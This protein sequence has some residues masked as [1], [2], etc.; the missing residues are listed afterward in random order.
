MLLPSYSIG[1]NADRIEQRLRAEFS[2]HFNAA[3]VTKPGMSLPVIL[4]ESGSIINFATWGIPDRKGNSLAWIRSGGIIKNK[5]TRVLIRKKRCLI[6][7]NGFFIKNYEKYYF[8]YFPDEPVFTFAGIYDSHKQID[9][10]Q[11]DFYFTILTQK[12]GS[13]MEK[14]SPEFPVIIGNSSRRRYL[15]LEKPLMDITLLLQKEMKLKLNGLGISPDLFSKKN[16]DKSDFNQ[17]GAKLYPPQK[18]PEKEILGSYYFY[19][20]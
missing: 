12:A 2:R 10:N 5:N 17:K 16:P 14:I 19:G 20:M 9:E 18:F 4:P 7:A 13:R 11:S 15:N 8:I 6:P 1:S 3:F